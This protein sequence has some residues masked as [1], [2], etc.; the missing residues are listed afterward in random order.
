MISRHCGDIWENIN[1]DLDLLET[2][3]SLTGRTTLSRLGSESALN[4]L[5]TP[6]PPPLSSRLKIWIL[7]SCVPR[8]RQQ[9]V[10]GRGRPILVFIILMTILVT[11]I[12]RHIKS[13]TGSDPAGGFK[14]IKIDLVTVE[15]I[16]LFVY[17][18]ENKEKKLN[19][20]QIFS[21]IKILI[22]L[23]ILRMMLMRRCL[24]SHLAS[25]I[26]V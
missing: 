19:Y 2:I 1:Y 26:S 16:D 13:R 6:C 5:V 21:V 22:N 8:S 7:L 18:C 10:K 9:C 3:L 17:V 14:E 4:S 25:H 23:H 15:E 20:S 24:S 12:C 11:Q